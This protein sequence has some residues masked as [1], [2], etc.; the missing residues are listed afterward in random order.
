MPPVGFEPMIPASARP[1]TYALDRA[2]TG[3]G[4]FYY[5]LN[6]S[7]KQ[8]L[9]LQ[10][11]VVTICV[12]VCVC[13][14]STLFNKQSLCL[15]LAYCV[16]VFSVI[17]RINSP[18]STNLPV[19]YTVP[20]SAFALLVLYNPL[21]SRNSEKWGWPCNVYRACSSFVSI[22]SKA[23]ASSRLRVCLL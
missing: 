17:P 15:F 16:C 3:I 11:R 10:S 14:Y 4:T 1:Q 7:C 19:G 2:A 18:K 9:P 5:T 20:K 12:C 8:A 23:V 21:V 22:C 13:V 6:V